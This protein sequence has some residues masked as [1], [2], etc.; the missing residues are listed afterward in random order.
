[1]S[2]RTIR[3][4]ILATAGV[5]TQP[6][7]V[8]TAIAANDM[9]AMIVLVRHGETARGP[10]NERVLTAAGHERAKE[11]AVALRNVKFSGV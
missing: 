2:S 9:P 10:G 3:A 5:V 1:M 11:L 4:M 7:I 8:S 6:L